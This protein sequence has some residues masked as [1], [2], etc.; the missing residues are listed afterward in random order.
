MARMTGRFALM[1]SFGVLACGTS[2]GGD[3]DAGPG[4]FESIVVDPAS[5][6]LDVPLGGTATQDYRVFGVT[7]SAQTEITAACSLGLDDAGFGS[8][9][10]ATL[11]ANPRGG[12]T[13]V[14]AAC[15]TQTG[16]GELTINLRGDVIGPGA[17]ANAAEL[18]GNASAGTD[19][20]RTPLIEYPLDKA[21]SPRNIPPIEA[22]YTRAGNDLFH[23]ALSSSFATIHIYTAEAES[24]LTEAD[25]AAVA[26]T[27]AGED[28]AFVVEGL[29]QADPAVKF[30][31]STTTVTMSTDTIDQTA[32]YWWSSNQE[33][34]LTQ[35]FGQTDAPDDV[36][37]EC[38]SCHALSRSGT[39][40]GYS[41]CVNGNC[42]QQAL[43]FLKYNP[44][45]LAWDETVNAN[46]L[47]RIG[48]YSTFAP[49]G[50]PFPTDDQALA[51][52]NRQGFL[53][54]VDP[55]TGANVPSNIDVANVNGRS[56]M[57]PD[58]SPD[59]HS[60]VYAQGASGQFVDITGGKI[61]VMSYDFAAN[62]HVFGTPTVLTPDP[63]TLT[64]GTYNNFFFPSFSPDNNLIVFNAARAAWRNFS[65]AR[66][67]GSRLMLTTPDASFV[68]DLTN[69]N[70]G[71]V[72]N[73]ITWPHWAPTVSNDYYWI[74]FASERD[75]GHRLTLANTNAACK[76]NGV[77][78]C[79]QIWMAAIRKDQL[80]AGIDPSFAPMW[81][82]GQDIRANNI[83]P[84]WTKPSVLQ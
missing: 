83:S 55:D 15:G 1:L 28:L 84:F 11:S 57:M 42:G 62:S 56:A 30:T 69:A 13:T 18:F 66:G 31:S 63:I 27:A 60:V 29:L 78:Q 45:T 58:W 68:V 76:G 4:T 61:A 81:V 6:T 51:M 7:G 47:G 40:I 10:A 70:G 37:A 41:R 21:V 20:V 82:P 24:L 35:V 67:T 74:V 49:V 79:K 65:N 54:L 34:I 50:N 9:A 80:G 33:K 16:T 32:I 2:K 3:G 36:K 22:Q 52:V 46:D 59:G 43:G 53:E 75:Y 72:D 44:I 64:N 12:K 38:T 71:F 26:Q 14:L 8:F 73:S 17:P 48:S 5:V 39:R 19:A 77:Q 23:V 25:W